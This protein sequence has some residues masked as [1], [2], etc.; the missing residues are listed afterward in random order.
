LSFEVIA[1]YPALPAL[2]SYRA[3]EVCLVAGSHFTGASLAPAM[4]ARTGTLCGMEVSAVRGGTRG[5]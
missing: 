1:F 2:T 5:V 4:K 3:A